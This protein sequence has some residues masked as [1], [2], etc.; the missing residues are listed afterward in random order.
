MKYMEVEIKLKMDFKCYDIP[1]TWIRI[2]F[3]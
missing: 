3:S 2:K 1:L